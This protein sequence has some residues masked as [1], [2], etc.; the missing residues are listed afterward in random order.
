M[1]GRG[2]ISELGWKGEGFWARM[3]MRLV[4]VMGVKCKHFFGRLEAH[5]C[6]WM[7]NW[8][9]CVSIQGGSYAQSMRLAEQ[10]LG[11]RFDDGG[12]GIFADT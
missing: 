3:V 5:L 11:I 9:G 7:E 12:D 4:M 8:K 1:E 10:I 2:S 6:G